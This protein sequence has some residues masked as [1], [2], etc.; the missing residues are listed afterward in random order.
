ML[1]FG[2]WRSGS[3]SRTI[4]K[5]TRNRETG[6]GLL[7]AFRGGLGCSLLVFLLH[8]EAEF[9]AVVKDDLGSKGVRKFIVSL[10][11]WVNKKR[12]EKRRSIRN[13]LYLE[14]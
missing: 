6:H 1:R 8:H 10:A 11:L 12:K 4:W 5:V 9:G 14:E 3:R 7:V 13:I 2:R